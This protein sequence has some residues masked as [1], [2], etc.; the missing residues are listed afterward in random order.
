MKKNLFVMFAVIC[1]T[2]IP[3]SAQKYNTA[4]AE[5]NFY[6]A[7]E[8]YKDDKPLEQVIDALRSN[9][10]KH[11][12]YIDSYLLLRHLYL[13][14][15]DF[16][17]AIRVTEQAIKNNHKDSGYSDARLLD[18]KATV[19]YIMEEYEIAADIQEAAIKSARKHD[20][21]NLTDFMENLGEYRYRLKDYDGSDDVYNA[22]LKIE[23]SHNVA[24]AGLARNLNVRGEY[25]EA[26]VLLEKCSKYAP[27]YQNTYMYMADAYEGKG[28]YKKMIDALV[29]LVELSG[30]LDDMP[31]ERMMKDK[32]YALAVLKE[33]AADDELFW[34]AALITLYE[35]CHMYAEG[36][37]LID[38]MIF[39]YGEYDVFLYRRARLYK[40][41]GMSELALADIEKALE[42]CSSDDI[43]YYRLG[44][45][46]YRLDTGDYVSAIEDFD[47]YIER[48][49]TDANG[50]YLRGLS[51]MLIRDYKAALEDFDEGIS[52]DESQEL[53]FMRGEMYLI[54]GET[55]KAQADFEKVLTWE[56]GESIAK[57]EVYAMQR[58]GRD[59]DALDKLDEVMKEDNL[60]AGMWYFKAY[61]LTCMGQYDMAVTMLE[62]A[63]EKGYR[64]FML[65]ENDY[66]MDP[67]RGRSDFNELVERYKAVLADEIA[68]YVHG[69]DEATTEPIVTDVAMTRQFGGT[70][71]V[72]CI[73]NG[74]PLKM[75]FDTGASDVTISSVEANFM[76][77]N[78]YLTPEDVKGKTRYQIANGEIHE[79]T[80]LRLKE[81]K[82][83]D[84]VLRNV[85]ASVV[86]NQKAPLLLGQSVLE[87]FGTIT[88][89]NVNS[90][91]LIKQ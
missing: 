43:W 38:R 34:S 57:Y 48:L 16:T 6:K 9:I 89:D 2:F 78:G 76:F 74:L 72:P 25:D 5:V 37:S 30:N 69:S 80:I 90:K 60:D 71:E 91:L 28:E 41:L 55:A 19:Y 14:E 22:I 53:Y 8:M 10:E 83:G 27:E 32:K 3:L 44:R 88:I 7:L 12:G 4:S 29:K 49:P 65:I 67:L 24:I 35:S 87:R 17:S 61:L 81:V 45:G 84:A 79:G 85:D 50:Y 52:V 68:E 82:L 59:Q 1:M 70:Y 13:E 15:L 63:F 39:V 42:I 47:A 26:V 62:T 40:G 51:R 33:R 86:H 77:K 36:V 75:I 54:L 23:P 64:D 21:E 31:A 73:V 56:L 20:K 11:P 58:L 66:H 46:S 18:L